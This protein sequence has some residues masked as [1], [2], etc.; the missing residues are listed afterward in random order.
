MNLETKDR[1]LG[2]FLA[3]MDGR[4]PRGHVMLLDGAQCVEG[5]RIIHACEELLRRQWMVMKD[6]EP[7][8]EP[9]PADLQ[10]TVAQ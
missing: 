4:D 10:D 7:Q 1:L 6:P 9:V 3:V 5:Y 8:P 2:M